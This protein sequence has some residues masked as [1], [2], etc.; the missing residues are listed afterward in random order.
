LALNNL[1]LSEQKYNKMTM[2]GAL[3]FDLVSGGASGF[4]QSRLVAAISVFALALGGWVF[5][6]K[7]LPVTLSEAVAE[8]RTIFVDELE[9]IVVDED[10]DVIVV[11]RRNIVDEQEKDSDAVVHIIEKDEQ[12]IVSDPW[13]LVG[14]A[15][16]VPLDQA[17][18][19]LLEAVADFIEQNQLFDAQSTVDIVNTY[20]LMPDQI[21]TLQV[22]RARL[23]NATGQH[24]FALYLVNAIS[25]NQVRDIDK[26]REILEILLEAQSSLG[27]NMDAVVTTMELDALL[28]DD[29]QLRNQHRLLGL[30][31]T[32]N[33]LQIS[34][35]KESYNNEVLNGWFALHDTIQNTSGEFRTADLAD[36]GS[37][38][39]NHPAQS[40]LIAG[41]LQ[42]EQLD[43]YNQIALLLP[44]TSDY[45]KAAR[46]FYEGF[47]KAHQDNYHFQAPEVILYDIGAESRL[48]SFYYLA[49]INDGADFVVGP[50]GRTAAKALLSSGN[51]EVPTL[52]IA[53]IPADNT[54]ENLFGISLSPEKEAIQ[55]ARKAF[56]QGHRQATVFRSDSQWGTRVASAFV[57]EWEQLGGI[58]VK[59]SSFP[60]DISDYSRIIQKF[61]GLD[62]S[63]VRHRLLQAQV[64][65]K[66]KFSARRN[67]DMD[68]IFLAATA[69]QARQ[70]APQL[71]FFKAHDLPL[72]ATS[73]VYSGKPEPAADH[74]LEGIIF[75]EMQWIVDSVSL[76]REKLA[77]E[78]AL[79]A[80]Q[81]RE[82]ESQLDG[83]SEG[84]PEEADEYVALAAVDS[85]AYV[86]GAAIGDGIPEETEGFGTQPNLHYRPYQDSTLDR[87][88]ALGLQSYQLIPRLNSLRSNDW[89]IYSGDAMTVSV[90]RYG[91]V[92][93]HP[94][95][96]TFNS[97]LV[98]PLDGF[99]S[100]A[101]D[102]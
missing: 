60:K 85:Q 48:T 35:L 37:T 67:E 29:E 26:R 14:Q 53:D 4:L 69:N 31:Q 81:E 51:S 88:Y 3:K 12:P 34:L 97:G 99:H 50:L 40:E 73:Y 13:E 7:L 100:A 59:N 20:S 39:P 36:W 45:G 9:S 56:A 24:Q 98:E 62:K 63:L 75:G 61:L 96:V 84:T 58:V 22:L 18:N 77:E 79:K 83:E 72:Y 23:A 17:P 91:S 42:L 44:L 90:S 94:V 6:P 21:F 76:Y 1:L 43:E 78:E 82:I 32:I 15:N 65:R 10:T 33:P 68:F 102:Q 87:L 66:L 89:G 41:I 57:A 80:E 49:A 27:K 28:R 93:R 38:F 74:D 71:R 16:T 101:T 92:E 86:S 64:E 52:V 54:N 5:A 11:E 95:W 2:G 47:T 46:A 25:I 55:V 8:D 30:L 70:V 19:I